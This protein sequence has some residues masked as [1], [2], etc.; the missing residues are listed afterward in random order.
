MRI[1]SLAANL[2]VF[3]G[4]VLVVNA[5]IFGLGFPGAA[6][7]PSGPPGWFVGLVW[8]VLFA[9]F[10]AAHWRLQAAADAAA[11][12]FWL[13]AFSVLCLIYPFYTLGLSN[14]SIGLAGNVVTAVAAI[15][16]VRRLW[17]ACVTA[18]L[19]VVPVI[20]WLVLATCTTLGRL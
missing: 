12:R 9:L 20:P 11:A 1:S 7:D 17:L 8:T 18:A 14:R 6:G 10:G 2:A 4:A 19:L 3:L 13:V 5:L 16:L 15:L